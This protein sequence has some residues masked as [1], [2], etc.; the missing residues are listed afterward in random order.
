MDDR[1]AVVCVLDCLVWGRRRC[2]AAWSAPW[3]ACCPPGAPGTRRTASAGSRWQI[4]PGQ[5]KQ[6]CF[7]IPY[8]FQNNTYIFFGVLSELHFFLY[9]FHF[10][11]FRIHTIVSQYTCFWSYTSTMNWNIKISF[12]RSVLVNPS[13]TGRPCPLHLKEDKP[14]PSTPCYTWNKTPW[15]KCILQ[16]RERQWDFFLLFLAQLTFFVTVTFKIDWREY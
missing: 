1:W 14:C 7:I 5:G 2:R 9:H 4:S 6:G 12:L 13:T 15:S 16:V 3:T 10:V 8:G 11:K